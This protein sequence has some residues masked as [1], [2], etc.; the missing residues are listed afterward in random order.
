MQGQEV[1]NGIFLTW[2]SWQL[3]SAP[4][5]LP[6]A[7]AQVA[8]GSVP[9]TSSASGISACSGGAR[10]ACLSL[11]TSRCTLTE[12][13]SQQTGKT[14]SDRHLC[15]TGRSPG[16][17]ASSARCLA[18]C[19]MGSKAQV[20]I[21]Q[22]TQGAGFCC[23]GCR[24]QAAV[25]TTHAAAH[26][27]VQKSSSRAIGR[28][29]EDLAPPCVYLHG[30]LRRVLGLVNAL[31]CKK[32]NGGKQNGGR[33]H[34]NH[35]GKAEAPWH[36]HPKQCC[37]STALTCAVLHLG[38]LALGLQD[39]GSKG[40]VWVWSNS[41]LNGWMPAWMPCRQ[42]SGAEREP[43]LL[44]HPAAPVLRL[45]ALLLS[46]ASHLQQRGRQRGRVQRSAQAGSWRFTYRCALEQQAAAAAGGRLPSAQQLLPAKLLLLTS[47]AFCLAASKVSAALSRAEA[48]A[49]E[50]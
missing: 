24:S 7:T 44:H 49:S 17:V 14:W 12:A 38:S 30:I 48:A 25:C 16:R 27:R 37:G 2:S 46:H 1:G 20:C 39:Q 6:T 18:D 5:S 10:S 4:A 40:S 19:S 42:G 29:E 32:A 43:H 3:H 11:G 34:V 31:A 22:D 36:C 45:C 41:R 23:L 33:F 26:V 13:R 21:I 47:P 28:S 9:T 50:I 35:T 8:A 15:C